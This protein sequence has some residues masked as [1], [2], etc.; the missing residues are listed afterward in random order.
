MRF[1]CPYIKCSKYFYSESSLGS[2]IA[3][4]HLPIRR[5]PELSVYEIADKIIEVTRR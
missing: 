3:I 4:V 5:F 1:K 2:H